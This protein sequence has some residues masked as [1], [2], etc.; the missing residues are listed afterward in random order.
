MLKGKSIIELIDVKTHKKEVYEDE[1]LVTNAVPDLLRLN[2]SGLMFP[3]QSTSTKFEEE[4]F[5][6]ANK[7]YGGILLFEDKLEEDPAKYIV[8]S[9]N[10]IIGY[11]SND[12]NSTDSQM[13]GSANLN[14]STPLENGYKFVWD[15]S[16]SQANGRI[17]SLA[18]THYR[19]GTNFYGDI[20]GKGN[21]TIK[22]NSVSRDVGN[23]VLRIYIG[24]VEA[25]PLTNTFTSIWPLMNKTL[26]IVKFKEAISSVGLNDKI[27]R[28]CFQKIEK[29][30]LDIQDFYKDVRSFYQEYSAFFD[31]EDGY[32]YGFILGESSNNKNTR[33]NRIKIKKEDYS[34]TID[35]W[36]IEDLRLTNVGSY[37]SNDDYGAYR[38]TNSLIK[39]GYLYTINTSKTIIIK[40]NI[41][42]PID[43]KEIDLGFKS[44]FEPDSDS[45]SCLYK[46]GD[47]IIGSD[48]VI[49]KNDNVLRTKSSYF[50]RLMTPFIEYGTFIIGYGSYVRDN[51]RSLYKMLYLMT[52]YLGTINNLSSPIL[53]T[54][55]KTMKITYTLT[56]E[57]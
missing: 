40:I 2:P 3:I 19:G 53:K 8:P 43:I 4:I 51:Y 25:N 57:E 55:D 16:T 26:E 37:P 5:P 28:E 48:F 31:G 20:Y 30:T 47:Y 27:S 44:N 22:L 11:A 46:Y 41:N 7:C 50:Y 24:M 42:N 14:E 10:K 36:T 35:H 6:I 32:Y 18:L 38:R 21:N 56:E 12:V 49:D 39:D 34:F 1:N 9:T 17:S 33:L 15:F 52:P 23:E 45:Y 54:A 29:L 13:R